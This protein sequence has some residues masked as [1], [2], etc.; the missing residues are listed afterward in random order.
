VRTLVTGTKIKASA[1]RGRYGATKDTP[2]LVAVGQGGS[3]VTMAALVPRAVSMTPLNIKAHLVEVGH[4]Q[5][6]VPDLCDVIRLQCARLIVRLPD[7]RYFAVAVAGNW[8]DG[9]SGGTIFFYG[10]REN[11]T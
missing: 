10:T 5:R 11:H 9:Y 3:N 1:A 8:A 6:V 7:W 4:R 2:H